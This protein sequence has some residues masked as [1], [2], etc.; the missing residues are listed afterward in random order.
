MV[1]T[2]A[3]TGH[4]CSS[5]SLNEQYTSDLFL[6]CFQSILK[7]LVSGQ[8]VSRTGV[9]IPIP[10]YPLYS[11]AISEL[12]AVQINYYLDEANCWALDIE[13]LQRAYQAAKQHC[14]P[15]VLCIINPGNP[16]GRFIW[17]GH[18]HGVHHSFITAEDLKHS[19]ALWCRAQWWTS[20]VSIEWCVF[21]SAG[22]VQSKKCIEEVLHFA[23]EENLFVMA[24]EVHSI[25]TCLLCVVWSS[26]DLKKKKIISPHFK[27]YIPSSHWTAVSIF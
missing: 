12:E 15:R 20:L 1:W 24:D 4:C 23:H 7:L 14:Q 17:W 11:A 22:Q 19:R 16:T 26:M 8:G 3:I 5:T 6:L 18:T 27:C 25:A 10:Q 21:L 2:R 9:M 13:E